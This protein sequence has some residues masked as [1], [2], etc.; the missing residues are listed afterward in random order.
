MPVSVG[1]F[2]KFRQKGSGNM[3]FLKIVRVIRWLICSAVVAV[4]GALFTCLAQL[5]VDRLEAYLAG[6]VFAAL[7]LWVTFNKAAT[8]SQKLTHELL[9]NLVLI[10]IAFRVVAER[11]LQIAMDAGDKLCGQWAT[12]F[13]FLSN[14]PDSEF[15]QFLTIWLVARLLI[16]AVDQIG[17]N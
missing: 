2:K 7:A 6:V 11:T 1:W 4:D 10:F 16:W 17:R 13:Y 9:L 3:F 5:V 14:R 15:Y 8:L 12:F